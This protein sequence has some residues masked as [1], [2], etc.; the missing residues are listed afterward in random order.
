MAS[1]LH[2]EISMMLL[3]NSQQI[4]VRGKQ[5]YRCSSPKTRGI[6]PVDGNPAHYRT[7]FNFALEVTWTLFTIF[8]LVTLFG[9]FEMMFISLCAFCFGCLI[10]CVISRDCGMQ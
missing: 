6:D 10:V 5:F 8:V 1:T 3:K 7:S 2:M 4:R 9:T